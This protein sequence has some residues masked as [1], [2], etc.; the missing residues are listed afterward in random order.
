MALWRQGRLFES[1]HPDKL[2]RGRFIAPFAYNVY[3]LYSLQ[4]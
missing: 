2:K 3:D 4:F 1:D